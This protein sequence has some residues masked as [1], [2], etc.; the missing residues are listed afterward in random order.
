MVVTPPGWRL[1]GGAGVVPGRSTRQRLEADAP[2]V[3]SM[4]R[5]RGCGGRRHCLA[6]KELALAAARVWAFGVKT[7]KGYLKWQAQAGSNV[8]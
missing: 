1:L 6:L 8:M 5:Q 7:K 2:G 4:V 3:G